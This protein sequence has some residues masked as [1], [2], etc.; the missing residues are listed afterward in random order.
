M[1]NVLYRHRQIRNNLRSFDSLAK[2]A[3][4]LFGVTRYK[5]KFSRVAYIVASRPIAVLVWSIGIVALQVNRKQWEITIRNITES[6]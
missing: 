1:K 5:L 4:T 6:E 3:K 2:R